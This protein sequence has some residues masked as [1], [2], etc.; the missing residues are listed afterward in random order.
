MP[1]FAWLFFLPLEVHQGGSGF[2]ELGRVP[3]FSD[4]GDVSERNV[5]VIAAKRE[6]DDEGTKSPKPAYM[7]DC[8]E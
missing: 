6:R 3:G 5:Q 2:S 8:S 4:T 7:R 1:P